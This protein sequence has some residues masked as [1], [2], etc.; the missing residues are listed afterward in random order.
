[1]IV[2][3]PQRIMIITHN[4]VS[5]PFHDLQRYLL[6]R[7]ES[8]V[9]LSHPLQPF[10][11]IGDHRSGCVRYQSGQLVQ[12]RSLPQPP[13]PAGT[14]AELLLFG[15]HVWLSLWWGATQ[16][17]RYDVIIGI[18][19]LNAL[20]GLMLRRLGRARDVIYYVIDYIPNRYPQ[21]W[22]NRLYHAVDRFCVTHCTQ[23]WNLSSRMVD[24][25]E[26]RGVPTRYRAKQVP[27][28]IGSDLRVTPLEAAA[29]N[30]Q[31]VVY[32]G[33][34]MEKQGVQLGIEALAE[35]RRHVPAARLLIIGGGQPQQAAALQRAAEAYGVAEAIEFAGVI[36]DHDE[37]LD[38]IRACAVGL[39]TYTPDPENFT[40]YTDP[41][42]PKV[43][44]AAGLPV[45]ITDVPEV[46][47]LIA[48]AGAGFITPYDATACA[49]TLA[50]LLTDDALLAAT[51]RRARALAEQYDW[52]HV[53]DRAW[54]AWQTRP[55]PAAP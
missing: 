31:T 14:G 41:A 23:V 13:L 51:K 10:T 54:T 55:G 6:T 45:V 2:V 18:N 9:C 15:W 38:R 33:G 4:L 16:G 35:L 17:R 3:V 46:A 11:P 28:P 42:K 26:A 39:A 1:M 34:L 48:A 44:L 49:R 24:A 22:L 32:F 52:N 20:V 29:V 50:R 40:R 8:L 12:N 43:Y 7:C 37:A 19:P 36:A 27:V 5:G 30:R 25:R 53:F 21:R 47:Q